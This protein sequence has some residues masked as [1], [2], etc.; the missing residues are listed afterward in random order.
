MRGS[1][2]QEDLAG[3]IL[4]LLKDQG[5]GRGHHLVELDL[6]RHF[7][8][9]RTPI[10]GALQLLAQK[11]AV[12]SRPRRGFVLCGPVIATPDREAA[13]AAD[14]RDN[15]LFVAI[16]AARN[17]GKLPDHFSQLEFSRI[18][19]AALPRV[20]RVLRQLA[21]LGLVERRPGHGWAFTMPMNSSQTRA[22][23]YAFRLI[24]EPAGLVEPTFELDHDWMEISRARHLAFRKRRWRQDLAVD[25]FALNLD[26]HGQLARSSGNR[27]ISDAVQRQNKLRSFLNINWV[28]GAGRVI[29][30]IDEHLA[31]LDALNATDNCLAMTL[32]KE[33]IARAMSVQATV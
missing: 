18:F 32:L 22:E 29:D 24:I 4:R 27:Y 17:R 7:Q 8:V 20:V 15:Q 28:N 21:G 9:S 31:V 23:S 26:F 16:A 5:V 1:P 30:S 13:S 10:R 3:R 33:H 12:E 25:F 6:C 14:E 11:G 2:L 19:E